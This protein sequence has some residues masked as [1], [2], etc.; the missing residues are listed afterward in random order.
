[1]TGQLAGS[2]VVSDSQAKPTDA[3]DKVAN[4]KSDY[5]LSTRPGGCNNVLG[6]QSYK[7]QMADSAESLSRSI[8][9][10]ASAS[11]SGVAWSAQMSASFVEQHNVS[12]LSRFLLIEASAE[13]R[14]DNGD[15]FQLKPTERTKLKA[16]PT[17]FRRLCGDHYIRSIWYGGLF[18]AV[19]HFK[20]RT[21]SEAKS[22][23]AK[24]NIAVKSLSNFKSAAE[25]R[26]E[27]SKLTSST[28]MDVYVMTAGGGFQE[29]GR[30][31]NELLE[32]LNTFFC[33]IN[34]TNAPAM[35]V[36]LAGYDSVN[37]DGVH[38]E[39]T[40]NHAEVVA[41]LA[42]LRSRLLADR[43][44]QQLQADNLRGDCP[45]AAA[46]Y[47]RV[48]DGRTAALQELNSMINECKDLGPSCRRCSSL[49]I[50]VPEL[51]Q[52]K[53]NCLRCATNGGVGIASSQHCRKCTWSLGS[54]S[55]SDPTV[56]TQVGVNVLSNVSCTR[57]EPGAAVE[58]RAR[59]SIQMQLSDG[60]QMTCLDASKSQVLLKS[61]GVMLASRIYCYG[62]NGG[63]KQT[64]FPMISLADGS[65]PWWTKNTQV[66]SDGIASAALLFQGFAYNC[67]N[68]MGF[69][70]QENVRDIELEICQAGYCDN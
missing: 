48:S 24:L 61:A 53:T 2:C 32:K 4:G 21:E 38:V 1:M 59:G 23:S 8:E 20:S 5:P 62:H 68:Y 25:F 7:I 51:N 45:D 28:E 13:L 10:S 46:E 29:I 69:S 27:M 39:Y 47:K 12:S 17:A 57:M 49:S 52:N 37:P 26:S 44:Y 22:V 14:S 66:N 30:S 42:R 31:P 9:A 19:Y 64:V 58:V 36:E 67:D 63:N 11:A 40:G 41:D 33:N 16:D 70:R 34:A 15:N 18:R 50:N 56:G 65:G 60:C 54:Y 55:M 6:S 43:S 35:K 3:K